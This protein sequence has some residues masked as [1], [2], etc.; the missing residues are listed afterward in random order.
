MTNVQ[1]LQA[2]A[3][4]EPLNGLKIDLTAMYD[5]SKSFTTDYY[6]N[7]NNAFEELNY[8][9]KGTFSM[10]I[11]TL[12]TAFD[13]ISLTNGYN[14]TS[15]E[16]FKEYREIFAERLAN[17]S[18][19]ESDLD[20]V[21]PD[22]YGASQ[23]QVMSLAFLAAYTKSKTDLMPLKAMPEASRMRPNW[24]LTYNGLN[25]ISFLKKFVKSANIRHSYKSSYNIGSY[26]TNMLYNDDAES[27]IRDDNMMIIIILL[28][29]LI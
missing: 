13:K 29:N 8:I 18:Y 16:R 25:K 19:T 21:F 12:G 3:T 17:G 1:K 2:K 20:D 24:N 4:I 23:Q 14:T 15:F 6:A 22:G 7:E 5:K 26:T 27:F 9:E 10:S 11:F 28:P